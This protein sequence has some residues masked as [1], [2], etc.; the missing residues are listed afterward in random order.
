M[1]CALAAAAA[2]GA[3][4]ACGGQSADTA[5]RLAGIEERLARL[6]TAG[7]DAGAQDAS[8]QDSPA[9][10]PA[11]IVFPPETG[12]SR[13]ALDPQSVK[14]QC[15]DRARA[16]C[17]HEA[18]QSRDANPSGA[19]AWTT[20]PEAGAEETSPLWRQCMASRRKQCQA[21]AQAHERRQQRE[22]DRI[23]WLDAQL[24][25]DKLDAKFTAEMQQRYAG[26]NNTAP[27]TGDVA[28]SAKFCRI[29]KADGGHSNTGFVGGP[30]AFWDDHGTLYVT[31]PGHRFPR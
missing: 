26:L 11:P 31:R 3:W 17:L 1:L 5:S 27:A 30:D 14:E 19:F 29:R 22:R 6:E 20:E 12:S 2:P 15:E 21:N 25:P 13:V 9:D 7:G 4:V 16:A 23:R 10:G 8:L 18:R 24:T 28:C